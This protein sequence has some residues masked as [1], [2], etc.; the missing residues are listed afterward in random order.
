MKKRHLWQ[1]LRVQARALWMDLLICV[2]V[3]L[4]AAACLKHPESEQS[5]L[6]HLLSQWQR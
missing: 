4:I 3:I 1:I 2:A 6:R 5:W